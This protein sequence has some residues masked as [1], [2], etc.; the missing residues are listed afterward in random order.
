MKIA[1][2]NADILVS[3]R[4]LRPKGADKST[5]KAQVKKIPVYDATFEDV[6]AVVEKAVY[7]AAN[8]TLPDAP[9]EEAEE[10]VESAEEPQKKKKR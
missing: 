1:K 10:A 4:T 5:F 8:A 3:V 2:P 9:S 7:E 6:S